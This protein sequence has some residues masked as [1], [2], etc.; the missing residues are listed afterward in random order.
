MPHSDWRN[1]PAK[2]WIKERLEEGIIHP[3]KVD[4]NALYSSNPDLFG[5]FK[6][7][8]FRDNVKN[9]IKRFKAKQP[10]L[11]KKTATKRTIEV[12]NRPSEGKFIGVLQYFNK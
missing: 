6:K 1:S 12:M 4:I 2:Q 10:P 7:P 5:R 8:A 11:P 3:D 9:L